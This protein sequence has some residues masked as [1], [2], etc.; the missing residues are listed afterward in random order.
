[1]L[2]RFLWGGLTGLVVIMGSLPANSLPL[3]TPADSSAI[4]IAQA[5]TQTE[6]SQGDLQKFVDAIKRIHDVDQESQQKFINAVQQAGLTPERFIAIGEGLRNPAKKPS[7]ATTPD[8]EAKFKKAQANIQPIVEQDQKKKK[9]AVTASG[10]T[11]EQYQLI[12]GKIEGNTQL[13]DQ[14]RQ[15]LDK[16]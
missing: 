7:P 9:Q 11:V 4:I 8:E 2:H 16:K 13:Q 15:M 3:S 10:L 12:M 6:V 1:M 14:V 5:S